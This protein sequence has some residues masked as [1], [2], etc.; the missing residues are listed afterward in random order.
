MSNESRQPPSPEQFYIE[1]ALYDE[2][3][4]LDSEDEA[5]W[6]IKYFSDTID[7]YC[8]GCGS[9]S[10]FSNSNGN[11]SYDKS[12]GAKDAHFAITLIC[13]RSRS[14][15]LYFLFRVK[16]RVMQKIGQYPSLASLNMYDVQKY[17]HVLDKK[18]F[19]ELTKAIG[20]AAHGVGVG[21]FVYL[22]RIFETLV[23]EAHQ[24]A[25]AAPGWDEPVYQRSRMGEKIQIL[26]DQLPKFLVDNRAMYSILSKGVH[27]LE[28]SECLA[29]FPVVKIGIE[30]ILDEKIRKAAE[31]K[32]L[33][34]AAR[35]IQKLSGGAGT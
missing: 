21:S 2:F 6:R 12:L 20:L 17:A 13:S 19:R 16:D 11:I 31:Q 27:E 15:T 14:H 25:L 7:A 24:L 29:A 32:K 8:P 23:E 10:I 5:A 1:Y 18:L 33:E 34:D 3:K 28:E 35:A 22:R 9:H 4:F 30:V 26:S